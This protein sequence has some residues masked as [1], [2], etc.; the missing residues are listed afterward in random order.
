MVQR[1]APVEQ[2]DERTQCR[3]RVVVLGLAQEECGATFEVPQVDVVA[4]RRAL[5]PAVARHRED[6]LGLRIVPTRARVQPHRRAPAHRRHRLGLGEHLGVGPDADFE[7]LGPETFRDQGGLDPGRLLRARPDIAQSV[8]D[9]RADPLANGGGAGGVALGLFLD[10]ALQHGAG[11]GHA[12]GLDRLKVVRRQKV[13]RPRIGF[14]GPALALELV[15]RTE[16]AARL[17]AHECGGV[18]LLQQV[19]HRGRRAGR[20]IEQRAVPEGH[21]QRPLVRAPHPPDETPG[22]SAQACRFQCRQL[23]NGSGNG[24]PP[25][26]PTMLPARATKQERSA[27]QSAGDDLLLRKCFADWAGPGQVPE[28]GARSAGEIRTPNWTHQMTTLG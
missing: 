10:H 2:A 19:M 18:V 13:P 25:G 15:N 9:H 24:E 20:D 12:A 3:R 6:D 17:R 28:A 1:V 23:L 4:E 26:R 7:I 5:D 21:D 14:R 27:L 11:E 8:A 16:R 22:R